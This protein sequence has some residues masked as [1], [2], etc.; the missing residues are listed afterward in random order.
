MGDMLSP[1]H[2][3]GGNLTHTKTK[4]PGRRDRPGVLSV[5]PLT[6]PRSRASFG[7]TDRTGRRLQEMVW[8]DSY[9]RTGHAATEER[10]AADAT[11]QLGGAVVRNRWE[12][13]Q[14]KLQEQKGGRAIR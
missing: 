11:I 4:F 7:Q 10:M 12:A 5:H 6:R 14:Q 9:R 13:L 8:S 2:L 3:R 1:L